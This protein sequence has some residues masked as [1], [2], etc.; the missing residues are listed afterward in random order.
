MNASQEFGDRQ[1]LPS[2]GADLSNGE[3]LLQSIRDSG[4]GSWK[5]Q[6]EVVQGGAEVSSS[7]LFRAGYPHHV[8]RISSF[9]SM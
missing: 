5:C 4:R 1:R 2:A 8:L 7:V 6:D 3:R 9:G